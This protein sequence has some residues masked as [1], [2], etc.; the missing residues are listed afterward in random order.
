ME[1]IRFINV[2]AN[3]GI[4]KDPVYQLIQEGWKGI[5]IEPIPYYFNNLKENLKDYEGLIF[6]NIAIA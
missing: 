6:E 4:S 2:G 5:L 3:D 1:S